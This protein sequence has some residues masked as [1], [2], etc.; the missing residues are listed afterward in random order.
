M[1][2]IFCK[3]QN[4]WLSALTDFS[5]VFFKYNW[6]NDYNFLLSLFN[7]HYQHIFRFFEGSTTIVM[8]YL[9]SMIDYIRELSLIIN[10]F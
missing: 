7:Y 4:I 3:R 5:G 1:H 8:T 6:K 9:V 2:N 10:F